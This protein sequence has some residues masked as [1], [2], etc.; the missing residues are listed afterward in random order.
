MQKNLKT[1]PVNSKYKNKKK[2]ERWNPDLW[3]LHD[4]EIQCS[5][6]G[7]SVEL[8][9]MQ[10]YLIYTDTLQ[11]EALL[12]M[13]QWETNHRSKMTAR[14]SCNKIKSLQMSKKK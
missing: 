3:R 7:I 12:P 13:L 2:R 9:K 8:N 11:T 4:N 10:Y 14:L 5:L 6:S 1:D